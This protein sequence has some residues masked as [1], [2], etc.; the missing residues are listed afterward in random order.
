[1]EVNK[2][3]LPEY[4][5]DPMIINWPSTNPENAG[6]SFNYRVQKQ[7]DQAENIALKNT[8]AVF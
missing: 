1:M 8:A 5:T 3:L 4:T 6:Y 7:A 2:E